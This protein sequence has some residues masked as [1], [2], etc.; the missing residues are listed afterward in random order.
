MLSLREELKLLLR[1]KAKDKSSSP[2]RNSWEIEDTAGLNLDDGIGSWGSAFANLLLTNKDVKDKDILLCFDTEQYIIDNIFVHID[3]ASSPNITSL[4]YTDYF[5]TFTLQHVPNS[6]TS[7]LNGD[8][9]E[10]QE[11]TDYTKVKLI[12]YSDDSQIYTY[13]S[14][15]NDYFGENEYI[16]NEAY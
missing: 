12:K 4:D 8:E 1:L 2:V 11:R 14:A 3:E 15:N 10:M 9:T 6:L 7:T 5:I 16:N 13:F